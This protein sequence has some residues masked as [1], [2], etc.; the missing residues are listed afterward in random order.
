MGRGPAFC[1]V[2]R[3]GGARDCRARSWRCTP[4]VGAGSGRRARG[5]WAAVN[6]DESGT[7]GRVVQRRVAAAGGA[8]KDIR[9]PGGAH[10]VGGGGLAAWGCEAYRI[11]R[12]ALVECH[13]RRTACEHVVCKRVGAAYDARGAWAFTQ[14]CIQRPPWV[15]SA[16]DRWS[17]MR[18]G[19]RLSRAS[20]EWH[21][22]R[23]RRPRQSMFSAVFGAWEWVQVA[24]LCPG[25]QAPRSA[26]LAVGGVALLCAVAAF[27]A[28]RLRV[29]RRR[30][31]GGAGRL[32][33]ARSG[34]GGQRLVVAAS[35][36]PPVGGV[37]PGPP[38][39]A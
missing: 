13:L 39:L 20:G 26:E 35:R 24:G 3:L 16:S 18:R 11:V 31:C 28:L 6:P 14:P 1:A 10:R 38:L 5:H 17:P 34:R 9:A 37:G 4:A 22:D 2:L 36:T 8:A 30:S 7:R 12:R 27:G 32:R 23:R 25:E 33:L 21:P 15:G 19:W 29:H